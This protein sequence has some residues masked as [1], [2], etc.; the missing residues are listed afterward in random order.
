MVYCVTIEACLLEGPSR[1]TGGC[2]YDAMAEMRLYWVSK[3][4]G[5]ATTSKR[6]RHIS[7]TKPNQLTLFG[8]IMSHMKHI[9]ALRGRSAGFLLKKHSMQLS[10]C[11]TGLHYSQFQNLLACQLYRALLR[12]IHIE[13]YKMLYVP[14]CGRKLSRE[15]CNELILRQKKLWIPNKRLHVQQ[16]RGALL[17]GS[18]R[19]SLQR[20]GMLMP[21]TPRQVPLYCTEVGANAPHCQSPSV[22]E[23]TRRRRGRPNVMDVGNMA[24]ANNSGRDQSMNC[25]QVLQPLVSCVRMPLGA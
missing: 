10:L 3:V 14:R 18:S 9:N 22:A 4:W 12:H 8:E 19:P 7:A 17:T 15:G 25:L 1:A 16:S 5:S 21:D 20:N 24:A 6:T 2:S 11:F 13:I 23:T